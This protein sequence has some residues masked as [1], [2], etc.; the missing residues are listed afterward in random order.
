MGTWCKLCMSTHHTDTMPKTRISAWVP[1]DLRSQWEHVFGEYGSLSWLM[2]TAMREMLAEVSHLPTKEAIIRRAIRQFVS[3]LA[4]EREAKR[5]AS[6]Q[7]TNGNDEQ[8]PTDS[9]AAI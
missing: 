1:E 7:P 5:I 9:R 2:E 6:N 4:A 8:S 3:D